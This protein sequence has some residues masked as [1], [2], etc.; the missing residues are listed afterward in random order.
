MIRLVVEV[1][2]PSDVTISDYL[3]DSGLYYSS[4]YG[5]QTNVDKKREVEIWN[6]CDEIADAVR[7]IAELLKGGAE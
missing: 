1:H 3:G 2:S 7:E 6:A 5:I 4:L